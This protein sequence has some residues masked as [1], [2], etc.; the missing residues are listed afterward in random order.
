MPCSEIRQ[1]CFD[2]ATW[3]LNVARQREVEGSPRESSSACAGQFYAPATFINM[4]F[5]PKCWMN[6]L[7]G[8]AFEVLEKG[9]VKVTPITAMETGWL[10]FR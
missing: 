3:R 10:L 7:T 4:K 1:N 2:G 9:D 8:L 5:T 6:F